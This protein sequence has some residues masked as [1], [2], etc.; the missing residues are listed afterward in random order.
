MHE[1]VRH[2]AHT[3]TPIRAGSSLPSAPP[4]AQSRRVSPRSLLLLEERLEGVGQ[5]FS[6]L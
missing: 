5:A 3:T 4:H 1:V 2:G 6:R